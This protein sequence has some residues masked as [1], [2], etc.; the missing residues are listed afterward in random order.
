MRT[1][2]PP[3]LADGSVT[4]PKLAD[5]SVTTDKVVDANITTAK[6]ADASITQIKIAPGV[7]LPPSGPA[8]GDLSGN[9][10][11]PIVAKLQGCRCNTCCT[12]SRA[13]IKI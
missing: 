6:L 8:G 10:P 3:K 12:G 9:Y 4:T 1:S 13:G 7:T 5:N 11:N 2:P